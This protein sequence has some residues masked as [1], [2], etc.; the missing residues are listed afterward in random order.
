MA[1]RAGASVVVL[2]AVDRMLLPFDPDLVEWLMDRSREVG[3]DVRLNTKVE[4]V[5]K[6]GGG[7]G[8]QTSSSG[9]HQTIGTDLVVHAAGRVPDLEPLNLSAA[10]VESEGAA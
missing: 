9:Q 10:H 2:E 8:V 4:K 6:T 5:E 1:S 3:I 7:F